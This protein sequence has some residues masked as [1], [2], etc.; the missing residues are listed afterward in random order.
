MKRF[1]FSLARVLEFRRRQLELEE[2]KIEALNAERAALDGE[3]AR[4]AAE[5]ER[6]RGALMVT[7]SVEAG[8]LVAADLYLRH[9]AEER[10]RQREKL[11]DWS[12]RLRKQQD[13]VLEARRRLRLLEK[14]EE[15]KFREWQTEVDRELENLASELFLARWKR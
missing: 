11:A 6:T 8:E 5:E 2:S 13:A 7:G 4:L 1:E 9:L 15:K 10:K 14:L 3:S 12:T